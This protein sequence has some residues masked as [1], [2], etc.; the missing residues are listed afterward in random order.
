[1]GMTPVVLAARDLTCQLAG[2]DVVSRVDLELRGH[3]LTVIVGPNGAG[4][5]TLLGALAGD[6]PAA[7]GRVEMGGRDL[8]SWTR[9]DLAR[10]R[11]FLSQ[12][13]EVSFG[14]AVRDVV[15]MGRHPW[16]QPHEVARDEQ[17][18]AEA[19]RRTDTAVL[20]SRSFRA[21]SGGEKA[22]VSLARV[23]AQETPVVLLDEPTA[24][25]DLRHTQDVLVLAAELARTGGVVVVVAHDLSL[26]ATHADRLV[27]IDH[28]SVLADGPPREVL[29]PDLVRATWGL[30]VEIHEHDS[31]IV[32]V[33][34]R[35]TT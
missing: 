3:E 12:A 4:K 23:L 5:S 34:V 35:S 29:T 21:L 7:G 27:V 32:V 13:N 19:M 11:A 20:G 6:V 22:R 1:M 25:L 24:A 33:P 30:D 17:V 9:R 18:V 14:F 10:H 31:S 16:D 28:G 26:A 8:R 2:R 15:A